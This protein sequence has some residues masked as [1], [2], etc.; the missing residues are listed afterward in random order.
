MIPNPASLILGR[1]HSAPLSVKL[2][3]PLAGLM[4][5]SM[6]FTSMAFV[7][8]TGLTQ[9]QLLRERTTEDAQQVIESFTTRGEMLQAS[10]KMLANDS[11][12]V[13][14]LDK[15]DQAS[16]QLVNSRAVVV[17]ER[18]QL[19]LV[20]IYNR[21][22]APR[23]NLVMASLYRQ[24]SLLSLVQQD[25]SAIIAVDGRVLWLSRVSMPDS[26]G[27]VICGIDLDSELHRV[28][29]QNHL[30]A[31]L[32]LQVQGTD[33]TTQGELPPIGATGQVGDLYV[34]TVPFTIS[35]AP[36]RLAVSRQTAEIRRVVAT[37]L[38][39]TVASSLLT[40]ALL[41][42]VGLIVTRRMVYPLNELAD[43]V[44]RFA[45]GDLSSRVE[46]V[47]RADGENTRS[48]DEM[49]ILSSTFNQMASELA[50]LYTGLEQKVEQRAN[51]L[52]IEVAERKKLEE[53]LHQSQ[54]MEAVGRL[55]GGV[56]HDFNN[57]LT[58]II[59]YSNLMLSGPSTKSG[60]VGQAAPL[61]P[62]YRK[63]IEL[64]L[65][66]GRRAASLT[67]Q[68]LA[69]SRRQTLQPK[70]LNLNEVVGGMDRLMRRLIGEDI[71]LETVRA[72]NLGP[73]NADPG[74]IEQVIMNLAVNA[75]DAM[76][77][78]GKLTIETANVVLD[79]NYTSH[80][81]ELEPGPYVMVAVSDT[82]VG[83]SP[84]VVARIFEP[85]FTTKENGTG[86]GLATVYGIV[87]QSG[88]HINVYSE[89]GAGTTFK[90]YLPRSDR[91]EEDVEH[92]ARPSSDHRGTE[93]VLLVEDER[94]VRDLAQVT[95][96]Q[97]G[98]T[99]LP[100]CRPEEAIEIA[101]R[102]PRS[103]ELILTDVVMPGMSGRELARRLETSRPKMKVL[104]M[105]GYT[106]SAI[107]RHGVLEP[108]TAF[109]QK[110]FT[111]ESLAQK[112][113]EVLSETTSH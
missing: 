65:D 91:S 35:G 12:I 47:S 25:R 80:Y 98:Y 39:V 52:D 36:A 64:I 56:A 99:V 92:S 61:D 100:A 17:R 71:E 97:N 78:G 70:V 37:G 63:Q 6:L 50:E 72:T 85:F 3:L 60:A 27:T 96:A 111:P 38:A 94:M 105:S 15:T 77:D 67:R 19:D 109:L 95:L 113:R 16:L 53:Q 48:R 31:N 23:T 106:D 101:D 66:A 107:S 11:Q 29:T 5:A 45:A 33:V 54:K 75:R 108:G 8:G 68:L 76:P 86:L 55:A 46:R 40:T 104:Y 21:A 18:M 10:A 93:T 58:V 102:H 81:V 32:R 22:G 74:Q 89:P 9:D 103:I 51:L 44:R 112:V 43:V 62:S 28:V 90:V 30:V 82:G 49:A 79:E 59:G 4:V 2:M 73:V 84:E 7:F 41:L 24:S 20:Q 69:F 13:N 42:L 26:S 88:G 1:L 87:K 34:T 14:A 57:L 110:P 83:M